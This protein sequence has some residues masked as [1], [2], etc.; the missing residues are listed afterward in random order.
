MEQLLRYRLSE[1]A[2]GALLVEQAALTERSAARIAE[3]EALV[4]SSKR[5]RNSRFRMVRP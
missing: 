1:A 5:N 3:L 2:K 4:R